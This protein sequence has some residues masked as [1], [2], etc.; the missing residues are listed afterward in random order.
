M[1]SEPALVLSGGGVRGAYEAGVIK[2]VMEVLGVRHVDS[3]PFR[4]FVG[5]SVGAINATYL[6]AHAHR[7]DLGIDTLID[8]WCNL[9]LHRHMRIDV[10]GMLGFGPMRSAGRRVGRSFLDPAALEDLVYSGVDWNRLHENIATGR[11]RALVVPALHIRTGTTW[12]FAETAPNVELGAT[13]DWSRKEVHTQITPE[14]ILASSA[15][16]MLYPARC[17]DGEY[18][19]DGGMRHNTPIK[20]ALRTGAS[21]LMVVAPVRTRTQKLP[22][23][24]QTPGLAFL[25]GQVLNSMLLDPVREE[26]RQIDRMNQHLTNLEETLE[27]ASYKRWQERI[28]E[29]RGSTY[30]H[31]DILA[32]SPQKRVA[33]EALAHLRD[34]IHGR[35]MG[36]L[37]RMGLRWMLRNTGPDVEAEWA[38]FILFDGPFAERLIQ[39]GIEE[40]HTKRDAIL[41][42]FDA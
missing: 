7:G 37:T 22:E 35:K 23:Q 25:M 13:P 8:R 4:T 32:F 12:V 16:P 11:A 18:F 5:T 6:T 9:E 19:Y 33:G 29:H 3:P 20:S 27:P 1:A 21:R 15:I 26:F 2:G 10:W 17:I 42:F 39:L 36:L 28:V 31:V 14:H 30:Q 24:M 34:H 40:A 38:T 41:A